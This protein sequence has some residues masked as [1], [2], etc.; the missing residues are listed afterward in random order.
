MATTPQD[1][2]APLH[3]TE[4]FF[5]QAAGRRGTAATSVLVGGL[6]VL[7]GLALEVLTSVPATGVQFARF[8]RLNPPFI[9][10]LGLSWLASGLVL[11]GARRYLLRYG[12]PVPPL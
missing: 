12:V 9:M 8:E 5:L 4:R 11:F 10:L 1:R 6:F 3:R 2:F 7:V